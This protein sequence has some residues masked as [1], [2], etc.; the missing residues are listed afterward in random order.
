MA[1]TRWLPPPEK[2]FRAAQRQF[3]ELY[4][5]TAVTN[6][7]LRV[8]VLALCGVCLALM[9]LLWKTQQTFL[10]IKPPIIRIGES[11]RPEI[12]AADAFAYRP[13]ERE[14]KYFLTEF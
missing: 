5:S 10:H 11:G 8:T 13:E 3:V 9:T 14:I 6:A 7:Y 2:D 1:E 4:G 12:V